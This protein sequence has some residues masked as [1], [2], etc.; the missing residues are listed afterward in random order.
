MDKPKLKDAAI[1]VR[2]SAATKFRLRKAM[3]LRPPYAI[4]MS[5]IVERGIELACAEI[6]AETRPNTTEER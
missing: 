5:T 4:P 6:E 3:F 2:L 1:T